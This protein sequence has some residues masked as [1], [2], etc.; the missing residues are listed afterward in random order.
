M[1]AEA[2]D[3]LEAVGLLDRW[4]TFPKLSG[5]AARVLR[6]RSCTIRFDPGR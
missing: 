5:G 4:D 6:G 1:R 3:L 2:R